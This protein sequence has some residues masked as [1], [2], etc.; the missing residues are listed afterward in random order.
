MQRYSG[1]PCVKYRSANR[2]MD[3]TAA[4][5]KSKMAFQPPPCRARRVGYSIKSLTVF[6]AFPSFPRCLTRM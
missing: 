6:L 4:F 1:R 2:L 3:F 5:R